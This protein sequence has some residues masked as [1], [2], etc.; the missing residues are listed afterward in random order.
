MPTANGFGFDSLVGFFTQHQQCWC[1]PILVRVVNSS[2][3]NVLIVYLVLGTD[4]TT[5]KLVAT[6]VLYSTAALE[7]RRYQIL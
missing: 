5:T 4:T 1:Q 7:D 2:T 3:F 6:A